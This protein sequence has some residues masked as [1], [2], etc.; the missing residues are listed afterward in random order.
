MVRPGI[1]CLGRCGF[2]AGRPAGFMSRSRS[3]TTLRTTCVAIGGMTTACAS[4]VDDTLPR[5]PAHS[6]L[7]TSCRCRYHRRRHTGPTATLQA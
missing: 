3:Q 4:R 6:Q 1:L 2:D 5:E 7:S